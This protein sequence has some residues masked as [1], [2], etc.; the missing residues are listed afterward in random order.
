MNLI[1]K[2]AKTLANDKTNTYEN[3]RMLAKEYLPHGSGFDCDQVISEKST[4]EKIIF[5][6]GYHLM[7]E[8]GYYDGW[9]EFE[10]TA[11]PSFVHGF[12]L[13]FNWKGFNRRQYK[14]SHQEYIKDL[15]YD[16]LDREV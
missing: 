16:L 7:S 3:M 1:Q 4:P 9:L 5:E 12:N 8:H 14:E 2:I 11:T 13:R 10:V 15:F 6:M